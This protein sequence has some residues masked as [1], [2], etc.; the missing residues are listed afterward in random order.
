M[1]TKMPMAGGLL[2]RVT[3]ERDTITR[4]DDGTVRHTWNRQTPDSLPCKIRHLGGAELVEAQAIHANAK[5]KIEMY[6]FPGLGPT[7]Y[8]LQRYGNSGDTGALEI[9]AVNNHEEQG[10]MLVVLCGE[11][12]G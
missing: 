5:L 8:R 6:R 3:V 12:L 2:S 11:K 7:L 4:N 9:L 1:A 10:Q